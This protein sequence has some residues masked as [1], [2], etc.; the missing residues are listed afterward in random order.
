M[1]TMTSIIDTRNM[2]LRI[3]GAMK[4][5]TGSLSQ[6]TIASGIAMMALLARPIIAQ[7]QQTSA[8]PQQTQ[9]T[10]ENLAMIGG[11]QR[12]SNAELTAAMV[13]LSDWN[14]FST[15]EFYLLNLPVEST[16][17]LTSALGSGSSKW[18]NLSAVQNKGYGFLF[19]TPNSMRPGGLSIFQ[20]PSPRQERF[21]LVNGF[22]AENPLPIAMAR[23]LADSF[24][25]GM[26]ANLYLHS[27]GQEFGLPLSLL[28]QVPFREIP[29]AD[30]LALGRLQRPGT[31]GYSASRRNKISEEA[32]QR[33]LAEISREINVQPTGMLLGWACA[34]DMIASTGDSVQLQEAAWKLIKHRFSGRDIARI[35]AYTISYLEGWSKGMANRS[36]SSTGSADVGRVFGDLASTAANDRLAM[37][38]FNHLVSVYSATL[39]A[40]G[41]SPQDSDGLPGTAKILRDNIEGYYEGTIAAADSLF[42]TAYALGI[43]TAI[44]RVLKTGIRLGLRQANSQG[45]LQNTLLRLE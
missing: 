26:I 10:P 8:S 38:F 22:N 41:G 39:A 35:T 29:A 14:Q 36:P 25:A 4:L 37:Q 11:Q 28:G 44:R 33:K 34:T 31:F 12:L 18:Y 42:A 1:K 2:K 6:L 15:Y 17:V 32:F 9:I 19:S 24:F 20:A 45:Q 3:L 21:V 27:Y 30:R 7:G 43:T 13:R 23:G 16:D 40:E 5:R